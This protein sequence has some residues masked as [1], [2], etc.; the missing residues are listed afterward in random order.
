M[1]LPSDIEQSTIR[2]VGSRLIPFL[3]VLYIVC[4]LDR[5]NVGFAAL[6]MNQDLGFSARA[7]GFGSGVFF[8]G[9]ALLEV[10]SNLL[11]SRVGARRWIARIMIS[12]GVLASSM[13]LVRGPHGFYVLRFLLGAA[14]AGF[15]PGIIFYLSEW[16]PAGERS[17]ANAT[18]MTAIPIS[19]IL[20]SPIS[21]ALL[22]MDGCLGFR[23]WQWL[24]VL[25]G[26]PSVL[27]GVA[28][29]WYLTDRPS[30][31]TWLAPEYRR[32]LA[33]QMSQEREQ[34]ERHYDLKVRQ[35]LASGTVWQLAFV[36]FAFQIGLYA[37]TLWLPQIVKEWFKSSELVIGIL[38]AVP[39]IL[40]AAAMLMV[41]VDASR[42]QDPTLHV[43]LPL[44][45]A[46]AGFVASVYLRSPVA[47]L[48][49]LSMT[50]AGLLSACGPFWSLPT[51]FLSGS[52][53]AAGIAMINS[54]AAVSGFVGPYA[55]G[56]LKDA[57][58]GYGSGFLILAFA[59][60][61]GATITLRLRRAPRLAAAF[62]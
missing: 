44:V 53:A 13:A 37:L 3:F 10:P 15:F 62:S 18:F 56:L 38:T 7:F 20:G 9:Y 58:G 2:S 35:V 51:K 26:L 29:L 11:L 45:V 25:E 22:R 36:A 31:A 32:W 6:Q 34:R 40:T 24:F 30:D 61:L 57:D 5:V 33:E 27:L 14:E 60:V 47:A 43:A 59:S 8:L 50:L 21:G 46:A 1:P 4:Y 49:A 55:V 23:G 17:R 12:W 39:Y 28:A 16:F 54:I 48:L 42:T 41:G 52:A 19:G